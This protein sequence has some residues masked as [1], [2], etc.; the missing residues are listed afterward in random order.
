MVE[1]RTL[2]FTIL[3]VVVW[4]FLATSIATYYY[5]QQL[6]IKNQLDEKQQLLTELTEN[7]EDFVTK[8]NL[9]FAEYGA[10]LGEYQRFQGD[11]YSSLMNNY[12]I[13]LSNL[14][15]NYTSTFNKFPELNT[16]YNLLLN[17]FQELSVKSEVTKEEFSSLLEE[18]YKLFNALS[19]KELE[20]SIGKAS[21]IEVSLCI[22][23]T[24]VGGTVEW[25]N[26]SISPCATLFDLT[27]EVANITYEYWATMEPGHIIIK[28][29]NNQTAWWLWYYWDET[30]NDWVWGPVGC[31]AWTLKNNGIYK[32][33]VYS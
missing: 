31:D 27:R 18:F 5:M 26:V 23:Y 1:K 30:I 32:W 4:A 24:L 2:T 22:N 33:D 9:L 16:T 8:R 10:L 17:E 14:K 28:S 7:Y 15:G 6:T 20:N 3:A 11:N 19:L 21:L 29:I 13:L 25:H 12:A